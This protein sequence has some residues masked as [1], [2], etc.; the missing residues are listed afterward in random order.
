MGSSWAEWK[1]NETFS[2]SWKRGHI[3]DYPRTV[4][5]TVDLDLNMAPLS[6]PYCDVCAPARST[7]TR[8]ASSWE[9]P[10]LSLTVRRGC[11]ACSA[12]CFLQDLFQ[13]TW[14]WHTTHAH[15]YHTHTLLPPLFIF[16]KENFG[17]DLA[18]K[19]TMLNIQHICISRNTNLDCVDEKS[20]MIS[21][22]LMN[23]NQ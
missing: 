4:M 21:T 10:N 23:V 5:C 1:P 3:D 2:A 7:K 13:G 12:C 6:H 20:G 8:S 11:S 17:F 22:F 15:T 14:K 18:L 19:S 9:L 16:I